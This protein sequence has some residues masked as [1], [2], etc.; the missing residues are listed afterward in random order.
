MISRRAWLAAIAAG[1]AVATTGGPGLS[2]R[3][4]H[5][6]SQRHRQRRRPEAGHQSRTAGLPGLRGRRPAGH[7]DLRARSAADRAVDPAR[8]Q[9]EHGAEAANRAGSG[10]RLRPAGL[11]QPT[12]P[13][14]STSTA[15]RTIRQTFTGDQALL[16]QAIRRTARGRIDVVLQRALHRARRTEA[17]EGD[18]DRRLGRVTAPGDRRCCRTARTRPASSAMTT[19]SSWRSARTSSST[20]SGCATKSRSPAAAATTRPTS[21]C[22]RSRRRP[23][24]GRSSS[25]TRRSCPAIYSQIADELANQYVVGYTSKN[26]KRDGAWRKVIVRVQPPRH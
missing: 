26:T 17:G 8:H 5:R 18:D 25:T 12:S 4:R 1:L 22:G 9:H 2:R 3:H 11:R 15:T 14:S 23:A 21:C 10:D 16:E 19:C 6:L 7:H 13:R 20:R 24:A